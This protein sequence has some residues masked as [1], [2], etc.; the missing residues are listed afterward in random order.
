[1]LKE[2]AFSDA[3]EAPSENVDNFDVMH[4]GIGKH[5]IFLK[6]KI[7]FFPNAIIHFPLPFALSA[8]ATPSVFFSFTTSWLEVIQNSKS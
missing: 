6:Y 2:K 7:K 5:L 4:N 1:M 8:A 3:V